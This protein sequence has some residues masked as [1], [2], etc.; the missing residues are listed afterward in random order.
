MARIEHVHSGEGS[1]VKAG[2]TAKPH[3][4]AFLAMVFP[5]VAM[6]TACAPKPAAVALIPDD[7]DTWGRTTDMRLDYPIP[8]HEDNFRI[9]YMNDTGFGFSRTAEGQSERVVFPDGT[10]IA[11][12]IYA[13]SSPEPGATPMMVTAM[14]KA[15]DNP[16]SRGGWVWATKDLAMGKESVI[17]GDFCFSCHTNANEAHPYGDKNQDEGFCDYVFFIPDVPSEVQ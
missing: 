1:L 15:P 12:A 11:K 6:L 10:V 13:G 2:Y 5:V 8:G 9:I 3:Y 4:A 17:T 16:A 7:Y 14:I